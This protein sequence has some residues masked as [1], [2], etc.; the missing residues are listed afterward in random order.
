MLHLLGGKHL[1]GFSDVSFD[2]PSAHFVGIAG[3]SGSGKSSLLKCIYRTCLADGG[4]M[5]Y[6]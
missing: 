2:V 5:L 3:K 4:S 6:R 1:T